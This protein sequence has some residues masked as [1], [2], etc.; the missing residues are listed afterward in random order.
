MTSYNSAS[1]LSNPF[2]RSA[3]AR[4][5]SSVAKSRLVN[6]PVK[7]IQKRRN[8]KPETKTANNA[9]AIN[10]LAKQVKTLQLGEFGSKQHQTQSVKL[11]HLIP[12]ESPTTTTPLAFMFN[13][14]YDGTNIFQGSVN[15]TGDPLVVTADTFA[16]QTFDVDIKDAYQWNEQE[17]LDTVSTT[18]YLPVYEKLKLHFTGTIKSSQPN[19]R[20][21]V[22]LFKLKNQ[23]MISTSKN[24]NMP[25]ALGAYWHMCDDIVGQKNYFS[26]K[27]HTVLMDKWLTISPPVLST[28]SGHVQ[29]IYRTL[30]LPFSFGKVKPIQYDKQ[31]GTTGVQTPY[32]N[33]PQEEIIWCLISSNQTNAGSGIDINIE[34][35]LYWRDKHGVMG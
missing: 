34:R 33:I 27:Y 25:Y 35:N 1:Q 10:V 23:P 5:A 12:A 26:K 24:M 30:E 17:N 2:A 4:K 9:K 21:R 32:N 31:S 29:H 22:T 11:S 13:S 8:R 7:S 16:K 28:T 3:T 20:Y 15:A 6:K 14:F 19:I 18:E